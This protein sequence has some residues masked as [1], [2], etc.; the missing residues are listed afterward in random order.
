MGP[1][2]QR[3]FDV[4]TS[5]STRDL[6]FADGIIEKVFTLRKSQEVQHVVFMCLNFGTIKPLDTTN[7]YFSFLFGLKVHGL[8]SH[9][10]ADMD[11]YVHK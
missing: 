1:K 11:W 5:S 3:G 10:H 7:L 6:N 9:V 8:I 2:K 4:I